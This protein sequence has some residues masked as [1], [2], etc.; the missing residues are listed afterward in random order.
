MVDVRYI[1]KD[2]GMRYDLLSPAKNI[3]AHILM[4]EDK[5]FG[6]LFVNGREIPA[7]VSTIGSSVYIDFVIS[8]N[9]DKKI[10][11]EIYF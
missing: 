10:T 3:N 5:H 2:E 1:L 8:D 9:E 4:P 7:A 11:I 6:K